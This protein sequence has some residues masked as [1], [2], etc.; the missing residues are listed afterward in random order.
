MSFWVEHVLQMAIH[1][2]GFLGHVSD[3]LALLDRMEIE[4]QRRGSDVRYGGVTHN[5]R[6]WLLRNLGSP[7]AEDEARAGVEQTKLAESGAQ[8]RL[9]LADTLLLLGR[10]DEAAAGLVD[11]TAAIGGPWFSNRWRAE[12]RAEVIKARLHL[13]GGDPASALAVT[14]GVAELAESRG[15]RALRDDRQACRGHALRLVSVE[16]STSRRSSPT[17]IASPRLP[18]WRRGGSPPTWLTTRAWQPARAAAIDA[19]RRLLT[20]AGEHAAD[21]Q[22]VLDARFT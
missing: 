21:L 13:V 12:Q 1:A 11:A 19:G 20:E 6:S 14:E 17:S 22:R 3:A 16:L 8:A 5:Y 7:L 15:D 18:R 4:L 2:N 10:L 9:D